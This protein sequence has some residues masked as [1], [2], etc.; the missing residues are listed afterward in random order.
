MLTMVASSSIMNNSWSP[1]PKYLREK[2]TMLP[3][4]GILMVL[5]LTMQILDHRVTTWRRTT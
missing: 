1:L 2:S 3:T 4:E 5:V